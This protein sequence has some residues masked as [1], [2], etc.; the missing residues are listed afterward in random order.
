[1]IPKNMIRTVPET[2]SALVEEWWSHA[3]F[4]HPHWNLMTFRDPIDRS[5][6]PITSQYWDMCSSGAQMAGLIRLEAVYTHGGVYLDSDVQVIRQF[7]PLLGLRGFAAWEDQRVI[8]DAI[9][10]AE[11]GHPA[12]RECLDVAISFVKNGLGA[13][14]SGPGVFT[15]VLQNRQDFTLF[16]PETF[17][18]YHYSVK[19]T[20]ASQDDYSRFPWCY[21]VH[22][23]HASWLR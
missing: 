5:L 22:H 17:Y 21:A 14:D 15:D 1:M 6:F 8:P 18:P 13:W 16:P 2:T 12:I 7:D 9:F 20:R 10:G 23:W 3:Q 11:Q 19:N 4:L